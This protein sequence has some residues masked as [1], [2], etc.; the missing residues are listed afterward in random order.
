MT[1][2]PAARLW[3]RLLAL[4]SLA[5][6]VETMFWGQM[7]A[8]MPLYLPKLGVRAAD[9]PALTGAIAA[10]SGAIGIPLIPLWGALADRYARQPII[11][12]SFV[13]HLVAG[14]I[15]LLA[16]N[17]WVF[18]L[19]RAVM[20]LALGNTGLMLTTLSE[21]TPHGRRST[22]FAIVNSASPVGA[23]VGPL[24]G[25]PIVDRWGFPAL[26]LVDVA[27]M[28]A[29]VLVLSFGYRD[30]FVGKNDGPILRMAWAGV[31]II[32]RSPRLRALFPALFLLFAG[33]T[34]ALTYVPLAI[35]AL[36]RG[37]SP[38]TAIG[39]VLGASG[40]TSL[41]LSP[42]VGMLADRLGNWRVLF[43]GA[44]VAVA[45]WP[46]PGLMPG[47]V[48][49]GVSWALLSGVVASVFA[50]SFSV[51]S[52]SAPGEVR[53][54]VM[55]FAFLPMNVGFMV[56]PAIG[57]VITRASVFAVFPAAALITLLGLGA[58]LIAA[59]QA[60]GPAAQPA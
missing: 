30:R 16:A 5:S 60:P 25:G 4:F 56:G 52:D 41:V 27:L 24:L 17:V 23:F 36:Y 21:W 47:L 51:L 1:G 11:V 53:G 49:F 18:V 14:A 31:L 28:L 8:F 44:A 58:L 29:V 12:R 37:D 3:L 20:S 46:I 13:V 22:A 34:L 59:R 38:G 43:G 48:G 33:W 50:I 26:L 2:P 40:L 6:L 10:I 19:G 39:Y 54:R 57:S 15:A 35:T 7:G 45:L 55:S 42:I 32:W 9:V